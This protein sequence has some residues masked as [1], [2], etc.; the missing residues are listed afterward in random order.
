MLWALPDHVKAC[1]LALAVARTDLVDM[2]SADVSS[3]SDREGVSSY[4]ANAS[5][6]YV[7]A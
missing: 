4:L 6:A 1:L 7:N 3:F 5:S 2:R